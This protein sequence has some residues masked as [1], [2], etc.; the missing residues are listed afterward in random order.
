[1]EGDGLV[2]VGR[3]KAVVG[4]ML[5]SDLPEAIDNE[6]GE[7]WVSSHSCVVLAVDVDWLDE[8]GVDDEVL[9]YL[10]ICVF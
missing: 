8:G 9:G 10:L 5:D 1:M 4:A 3:C 6:A 7:V 2:D